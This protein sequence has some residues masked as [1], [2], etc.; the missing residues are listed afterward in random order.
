MKLLFIAVFFVV[1][2]NGLTCMRMS[3]GGGG[4]VPV[5]PVTT[6]VAPC[7]FMAGNAPLFVQAGTTFLDNLYGSKA[8]VG[9]CQMCAAGA[10]NYYTPATLAAPHQTDP[11]EAIGSLNMANCPN[12]CVCNAANVCYRRATDDTIVT[13]W[14]YCVGATCATYGYLSGLGGPT[15]LTPVAGGTGF[16]A[17]NQVD[18]NT[19]LPKPVTDPSYPQI[20]SVGCNGCPVPRC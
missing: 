20:A 16:L 5:T 19:F 10:L 7:A 11:L 18:P 3:S 8:P 2:E 17:D 4:D 1:I 12:L 9:N 13:F 15:G 14:P 6:T